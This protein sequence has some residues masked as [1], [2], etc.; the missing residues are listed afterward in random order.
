M[1]GHIV[2]SHDQIHGES[3]KVVPDARVLENGT[4]LAC[5]GKRTVCDELHAFKLTISSQEDEF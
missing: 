3:A 1:E 2:T 4:S 5:H